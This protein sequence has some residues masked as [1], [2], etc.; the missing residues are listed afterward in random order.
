LNRKEALQ[1]VKKCLALSKSANEHE[2]ALALKKAHE[3]MKEYN[4]T[5]SDVEIADVSEEKTKAGAGTSPVGWEV[6]LAN[7]V[8]EAFSCRAIFDSNYNFNKWKPE[9]FWKFIGAS[10]SPELSKF[11]FDVLY[12]QLKKERSEYIKRK[13]YRCKRAN[14][15]ARADA[16]CRGWVQTVRGLVREFANYSPPKAVEQYIAANYPSLKT[17]EVEPR[18]GSG[19]AK[20]RSDE[21]YVNGAVKGK[22]ARLNHGVGGKE[23]RSIR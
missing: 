3:L 21:D 22:D 4:I 8:A 15:T 13:L 17:T 6:G 2:A 20:H 23:Q 14:K 11:A 16:F 12:R 18:E 19:S 10:I 5:E 1:K 9:G 7:V